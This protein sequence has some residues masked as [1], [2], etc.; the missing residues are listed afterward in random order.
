M[1]DKIKSTIAQALGIEPEDIEEASRLREDLGL[2][3]AELAEII[4]HINKD[5]NIYIPTE[6]LADLSS[7]GDLLALVENY[8]PEEI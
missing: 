5:W 8:V 4:N 3:A 7:V 2:D 1:R 6:D